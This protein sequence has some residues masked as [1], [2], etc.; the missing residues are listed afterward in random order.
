MLVLLGWW[1]FVAQQ[2]RKT[3][4]AYR[5]DTWRQGIESVKIS[6]LKAAREAKVSILSLRPYLSGSMA[7]IDELTVIDEN[8]PS[9]PLASRRL[10]VVNTNM[11]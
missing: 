9:S 3:E 11:C 10:T 1:Y 6:K 7:G 8:R 4:D 2:N 5:R